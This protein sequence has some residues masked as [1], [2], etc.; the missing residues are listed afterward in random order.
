[1]LRIQATFS[2]ISRVVDQVC[3][4][5]CTVAGLTPP[6]RP[7]NHQEVRLKSLKYVRFFIFDPFLWFFSVRLSR[8]CPGKS[9]TWYPW[10]PV[11]RLYELPWYYCTFSDACTIDLLR[12]FSF[13][14]LVSC[15]SSPSPANPKWSFH[16]PCHFLRLGFIC[17]SVFSL[18]NFLTNIQG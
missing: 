5:K 8:L 11:Y 1:M 12:Y 15:S 16:C 17:R 9:T 13:D 3:A 10:C 2:N 18:E 4:L 14:F 6:M 7:A